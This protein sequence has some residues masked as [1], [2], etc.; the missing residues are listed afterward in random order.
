MTERYFAIFDDQ[1]RRLKIIHMIE[2]PGLPAIFLPY[3]DGWTR[4]RVEITESSETEPMLKKILLDGAKHV[5]LW[6]T[7]WC[8]LHEYSNSWLP[9]LDADKADV[10]PGAFIYEGMYRFKNP[11]YEPYIELRRAML[12]N[13]LKLERERER[14]SVSV[15]APIP[16]PRAARVP[17]AP[18]AYPRHKPPMFVASIIKRDAIANGM[19]CAISLEEFTQEMKTQVTP[20][21]HIF[22]STQLKEWISLKGSC[23]H[24]KAFISEED[25]LVL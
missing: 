8:M 22:E 10:F 11:L 6:R 20:C 4:N 19:S 3:S 15:T 24:C 18:P 23:P 25:C 13:S 1:M 21:F 16:I 2:R 17:S 5:Y 9:I 12:L 7:P 14:E